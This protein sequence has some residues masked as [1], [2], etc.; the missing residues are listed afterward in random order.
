[1]K[2]IISFLLVILLAAALLPAGV[3][4]AD[5]KVVPS[6]QNLRVNGKFVACEKY[7]ID[8]SNYFKLRDIAY[9]LRSTG[10][11]FSVSWDGAKKCISL[12]S[13]EAY[14]PNGTELDLSFGDK[15]ASA[16]PSEDRILV[17]GV[18][19]SDLS[20]YK[21]E[22]NNFYKLRDLGDALGFRVDYDKPSNTAIIISRAWAWP[23]EYLTQEYIYN[24]D[25]AATSHS[26]TVY[27]ELGREVSYLSESEYGSEGY[28]Y[29]YDELGRVVKMVRDN[30]YDYGE[31]GWE[32]HSTTEY[33]Y[34]IWGLLSKEN[35]QAA[36]DVVSEKTYTYDERG[37][38]IIEETL[39]NAGSSAVYHSYDENDREIQTLYTEDGEV[40]SVNEY[41]RDAE[42]NVV[43]SLATSG[44]G[45]VISCNEY[46]YENGRLTEETDSYGDSV[47][48]YTYA[49]DEMGNVIHTEAR[50]PY[51]TTVTDSVF[52]EEGRMVQCEQSGTFGSSVQVWTYDERG[53]EVKY[54]FTDSSGSYSTEDYTYDEE[55]K[56][57]TDV[58]RNGGFTRSMTYTY[59]REAK[60]MTCLVLYEYEGVG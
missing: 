59:D 33:T 16:A 10:S 32:E 18:E 53:L 22:G 38:L 20:A 31:E 46:V 1:M 39:N 25:G 49:Y 12:V 48:Y 29:T 27:D 11:Q 54:E 50:D 4:A 23:T 34:D 40:M 58:Y 35:Y 7:N 14:E 24:E 43:R 3:L 9:V 47:Y 52:D 55:G 8:G 60:K 37:N 45:E 57:L 5:A 17:N 44:D 19:R 42:G 30:V 13:G 56:I 15:S 41:T 36:G 28:Q 26:V 6:L 2:R 21:L 51:G